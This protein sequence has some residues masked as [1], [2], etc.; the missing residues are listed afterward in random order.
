MRTAFLPS[1]VTCVLI[2]AATITFLSKAAG[3]LSKPL[4]AVPRNPPMEGGQQHPPMEA[5]QQRAAS[6]S[7]STSQHDARLQIQQPAVSGD[8]CSVIGDLRRRRRCWASRRNSTARVP[9]GNCTASGRSTRCQ[10]GGGA[11]RMADR[12][13]PC[14]PVSTVTSQ[15]S[16]N[17]SMTD[18]T[19]RRHCLLMRAASHKRDCSAG[20]RLSAV[21][22]IALMTYLSRDRL[23]FCMAFMR[24]YIRVQAVQPADIHVLEVD[25]PSTHTTGRLRS[26]QRGRSFFDPC[27]EAASQ[28]GGG[29]SR[30][31]VRR[32]RHPLSTAHR[33]HPHSEEH[34]LELVG[35]LQH[36]LLQDGK[37]THTLLVDVHLLGSNLRLPVTRPWPARCAC[38]NRLQVDEIVMVDPL[39]YR[40]LHDY[41]TRNAWRIAVAAR[42]M[43]VCRSL[44]LMSVEACDA[45]SHSTGAGPA[46][47]TSRRTAARLG[48]R[49]RSTPHS[50]PHMVPFLLTQ[51]AHPCAGASGFHPLSSYSRHRLASAH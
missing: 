6:S 36:E 27:Y 13:V 1:A 12:S 50:S 51:Q 42:G 14:R 44:A 4:R 29:S 32:S 17:C 47:A 25:A 39:K 45:R 16:G 43:E 24:Y 46:R 9:P 41:V 38:P 28:G 3:H 2:G 21:P 18:V 37:Y 30:V 10:S 48:A 7:S 5:G 49:A 23:E 22:H 26:K 20:P 8:A 34:K 31:Q 15:K 19:R 11:H 33:P 40:G 35:Q